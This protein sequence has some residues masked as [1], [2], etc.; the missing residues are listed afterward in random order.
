[1]YEKR[2]K[3]LISYKL[4]FNIYDIGKM[5]IYREF[6][7]FKVNLAVGKDCYKKKKNI[8]NIRKK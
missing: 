2:R 7:K 8:I 5:N 3:I 6:V 1:L 4:L